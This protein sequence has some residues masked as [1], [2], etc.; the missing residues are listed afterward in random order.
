MKIR[1]T[2]KE[3]GKLARKC[4]SISCYN[5]V[6]HDFCD[7]DEEFGKGNPEGLVE[8]IVPEEPAAEWDDNGCCTACGHFWPC[9]PLPEA[10]TPFC[11][12]CGKRMRNGA[13]SPEECAI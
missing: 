2:I 7:K 4:E 9:D 8:E 10:L 1:C 12:H 11:P 5:C 3:L 13:E 6:L